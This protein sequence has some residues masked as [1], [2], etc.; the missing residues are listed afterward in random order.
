M[1]RP[2]AER[3]RRLRRVAVAPALV[4]LLNGVFGFA[5]IHF[6]ARGMNDP[7]ALWLHKPELTFFAAAA[8]MI[9]LA[10]VADGLDGFLARMTR[11]ASSF[12]GQLDSLADVISFGVAP[13]FLMLRVVESSL[14]GVFGAASPAFGSLGGKV[15]WGTAAFYVCCTALRLARFNVEHSTV[16]ELHLAFSGLPSPAAAG[17]VA[18]LVLLYGDLAWQLKE[19][20]PR[21]VQLGSQ[22]IVWLLPAVTAGMGVLM[23]SRVPYRH[24]VNQLL[25]GRKPFGHFLGVLLLVLCLFMQPQ[26]TLAGAFLSYTLV[27]LGAWLWRRWR[28][29]STVGEQAPGPEALG[30][31]A[32]AGAAVAPSPPG[33]GSAD[34]SQDKSA[35]RLRLKL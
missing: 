21:A 11:G 16:E 12:G 28:S 4:T 26:L 33:T 18:S 2:S 29:L 9:F 34:Q 3:R 10:M 1:R 31:T 13:A 25:R 32:Q 23:V 17:V 19:Q 5:A 6:T 8:W 14:S 22:V 27:G 24:L 7:E 20:A 30:P 35:S 15:L